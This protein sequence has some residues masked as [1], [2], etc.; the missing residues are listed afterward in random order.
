MKYQ[1]VNGKT[2]KQIAILADIDK[3]IAI[4]DINTGKYPKELSLSRDNFKELCKMFKGFSVKDEMI[5][6][7]VKIVSLGWWK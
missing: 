1:I 7:G 2:K 3:Y 6:S 5:R 4:Y